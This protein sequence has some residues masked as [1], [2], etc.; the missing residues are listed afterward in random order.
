MFTRAFGGGTSGIIDL[1]KFKWGVSRLV[2]AN[3]NITISLY[4][5]IRPDA[6]IFIQSENNGASTGQFIIW[7]NIN[8]DTG[9]I[10][11][12]HIYQKIGNGNWTLSTATFTLNQSGTRYTVS[13]TNTG[14][15]SIATYG[16]CLFTEAQ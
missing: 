6:I 4:P 7:T 13:T 1:S 8:P 10:N 14:W 3:T 2:G 16:G 9:E 12:S 15:G 5:N 11:N